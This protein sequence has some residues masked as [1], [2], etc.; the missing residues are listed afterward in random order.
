MF[1]LFRWGLLLPITIENKNKR[2]YFFSRESRSH[3]FISFDLPKDTICSG[4]RILAMQNLL[5]TG[6]STFFSEDSGTRT[7]KFEPTV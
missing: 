6:I 4:V 7:N 1:P 5:K 3:F 2:I